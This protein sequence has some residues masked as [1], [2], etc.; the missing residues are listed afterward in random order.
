M[1]TTT[2]SKVPDTRASAEEIARTVLPATLA[3]RAEKRLGR[4]NWGIR[5][6]GPGLVR[7]ERNCRIC[8]LAAYLLSKGDLASIDGPHM[9]GHN[10]ADVASFLLSRD[11]GKC[12]TINM[13]QGFINKFDN[14]GSITPPGGELAIVEVMIGRAAA[15]IV[16]NTLLETP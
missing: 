4:T 9:I 12:V 15:D 14:I 2:E 5:W 8:P 16:D 10:L 11:I 3:E 1:T 13:I 7:N 6:S